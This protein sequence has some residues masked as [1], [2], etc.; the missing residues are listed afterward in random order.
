[1][2]HVMSTAAHAAPRAK[3]DKPK[4]GPDAIA[5][6]KADHKTVAD[7]FKE[8]EKSR[9]TKAK[10]D[11]AAEICDELKVHATIEEWIALED[12]S[13]FVRIEPAERSENPV[14]RTVLL[15]RRCDKGFQRLVARYGTRGF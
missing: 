1:M 7:L 3:I 12:R 4:V 11:I 9:D 5:L 15:P 13:D 2:V 14:D 10:A 8:Y 6:L